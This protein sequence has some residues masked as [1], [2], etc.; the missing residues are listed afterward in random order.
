MRIRFFAFFAIA[1]VFALADMGSA[2]AD[3]IFHLTYDGC[4]G[5]CGTNGQGSNN[6]DF[7]YIDLHQVSATEVLLTEQL[8]TGI[9]LDS[10][11][12]NTGGGN[13]Q[14]LAFNVDQSVSI[15]NL[16][17]TTYFTPGSGS[18]TISGMGL[19]SNYIAC[20]SSC[21][22]GSSGAELYPD[23]LLFSTTNGSSLSISDFLNNASG[24]A[25]ASDVIGPSGLTG[26][27]A[28]IGPGV[29]C[30]P[31]AS[32][33]ADPYSSNSSSGGGSGAAVPEPA[34]L[35]VMGAGLAGI[36]I[37]RRRRAARG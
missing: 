25:F 17:N 12:V 9:S 23:Q 35:F 10:D 31:S 6:N 1:A 5:G 4:T 7:G 24:Y 13:H 15:S 34:S 2:K 19:F 26:E 36:G 37:I 33:C 28:A 27:V 14:P 16:S 18:V 11:F 29:F 3:I 32:N 21:P 30:D 8:N 20:T 22:S